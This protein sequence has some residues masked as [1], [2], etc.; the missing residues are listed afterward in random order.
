MANKNPTVAEKHALAIDKALDQFA[1]RC[2]GAAA[3]WAINRLSLL[4]AMRLILSDF[5]AFCEQVDK[6]RS[7]T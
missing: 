3:A 5:K 4:D 2:R 7:R 6:I 1:R